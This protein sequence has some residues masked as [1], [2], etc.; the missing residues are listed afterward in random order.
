VGMDVSLT[1]LPALGTPSFYWV[2]LSGLNVKA[3]F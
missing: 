2:T 1:L 3:F